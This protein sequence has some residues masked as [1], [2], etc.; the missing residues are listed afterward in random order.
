MAT[1]QFCEQKVLTLCQSFGCLSLGNPVFDIFFRFHKTVTT[2]T[3][4]TS[5]VT[6]V[7]FLPRCIETTDPL[8]LRETVDRCKVPLQ[9]IPLDEMNWCDMRPLGCLK[10]NIHINY[11]KEPNTKHQI[12]SVEN[13]VAGRNNSP[14]C[15]GK[16]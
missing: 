4:V 5:T 9:L 8:A 3:T 13:Q 11:H 7:T 6:L 15:Q 12:V 2:L 14:I 16:V 1:N 10:L